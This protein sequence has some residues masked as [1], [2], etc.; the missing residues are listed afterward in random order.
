MYHTAIILRGD[1]P[2][3]I[4][5]FEAFDRLIAQSNDKS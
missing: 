4:H 1:N 5:V 2:D 3:K